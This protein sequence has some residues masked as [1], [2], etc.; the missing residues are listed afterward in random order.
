MAMSSSEC[1]PASRVRVKRV[2]QALLCHHRNF[3]SKYNITAKNI[4]STNICFCGV[5]AFWHERYMCVSL[6]GRN[7]R[8]HDAV[9]NNEQALCQAFQAKGEQPTSIGL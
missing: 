3:L 4:F 7:K 1:P 5:G 9:V 6:V 2:K 8:K